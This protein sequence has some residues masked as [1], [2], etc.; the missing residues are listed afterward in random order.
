MFR[1][2][3]S[4]VGQEGE[5]AKRFAFTR[6]LAQTQVTRLEF[7][8]GG[9]YATTQGGAFTR[10]DL[11]DDTESTLIEGGASIWAL[12]CH[13]DRAF[14]AGKSGA[15]TVAQ[16][17]ALVPIENVAHARRVVVMLPADDGSLLT[18]D[19]DGSVIEWKDGAGRQV[20]D[21][22]LTLEDGVCVPGR[23]AVFG[24]RGGLRLID[25]DSGAVQAQTE[26]RAD[27]VALLSPEKIAHRVGDHVGFASLPDLATVGEVVEVGTDTLNALC[28]VPGA[29]GRAVGVL[30]GNEDG[31]VCF[32][33]TRR[34][35]GGTRVW[36]RADHGSDRLARGGNHKNVSSIVFHAGTRRFASAATD[37][38]VR[39]YDFDA[40]PDTPPLLRIAC[41]F[42]LF[43]RIAFSPDGTLLAIPSSS[44][45]EVYEVPSGRRVGRFGALKR[46]QSNALAGCVFVGPRRVLVGC[47]SGRLFEV[48]LETERETAASDVGAWEGV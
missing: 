31:Q 33:D 40:P 16:D 18:A 41:G 3:R 25:L 8:G 44:N 43:N 34:G 12:A 13:G 32:I 29:D 47:D 24:T 38:I 20:A 15:V 39:V 21:L 1:R 9:L 22:G 42:G 36:A 10:W 30:T 2:G 37:H 27:D 23:C 5:G 19:W 46:F 6:K 26:A 17:G 7:Q 4:W 11:G 14:A 45:L 48:T 28:V 35:E